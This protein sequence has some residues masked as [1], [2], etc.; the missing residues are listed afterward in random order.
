MV[1]TAFLLMNSWMAMSEP[2]YTVENRRIDDVE[3]YVLRDKSRD[4]EVRVAPAL[5]NNSY[6]MTVKGKRV[7]WN[8][9]KTV[10][11][12]AARPAMLGNP[13]LWPWANRIDGYSYWVR[14]KQYALQP[15]LKNFGEG[16][17]GVPIHGLLVNS[18][19]WKVVLAEADE[20][21]ARIRSRIEFTKEPEL[22]AQFPFAHTIE[23]IYQLKDGGL[24]VVTVVSN[25]GNRELPVSLGFHPYFQLN[26]APRDEWQVT[27]PVESKYVLNEKLIPTGQQVAN[28]YA[29]PQTLAGISLD[30][31]FGGLKRDADGMARFRVKGAKESITV[32]FG[33]KY[34]I[35]VVYA[36]KGRNFICFEPMTGPTN[37]FNGEHE[38]WFRDLQYV[39]PGKTWYETFRVVPEGF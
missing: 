19:L 4:M 8:P 2:N 1:I 27:L 38:G 7:F 31:V 14:D 25:F 26:D 17:R 34:Q 16:P 23:V 12:F 5:G 9:Y 32:E 37:A 15:G 6:E 10:G 28:P 22:M 11:E 36:P 24:D 18:K 3:V 35:A 33:P 29:Q 30:D 13:M 20:K 39:A 21:G